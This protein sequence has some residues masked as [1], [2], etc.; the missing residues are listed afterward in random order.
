MSS[1]LFGN[2]L[3]NSSASSNNHR[4]A[5]LNNDGPSHY[6]L[7]SDTSSS[8]ETS[9]SSDDTV[10]AGYE[11]RN[12]H[13]GPSVPD[14]QSRGPSE[15]NLEG[16]RES[17]RMLEGEADQLQRKHRPPRHGKGLAELV[18]AFF[19]LIRAFYLWWMGVMASQRDKVREARRR[20]RRSLPSRGEG[21]GDKG[22]EGAKRGRVGRAE[23]SE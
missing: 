19:Q 22:L 4:P 6:K 14:H 7:L 20:R 10:I 23:C 1:S 17:V 13:A 3:F 18:A 15:A 21:G 5:G 8:S 9:P 11:D 16:L 12:S 2:K